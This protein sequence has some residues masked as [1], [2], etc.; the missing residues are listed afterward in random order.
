M[1]LFGVNLTELNEK[2]EIYKHNLKLARDIVKQLI[3]EAHRQDRIVPHSVDI[4]NLCYR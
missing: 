1:L 3:E 2:L 4:L